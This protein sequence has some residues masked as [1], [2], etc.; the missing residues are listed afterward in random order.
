MPKPKLEY[1]LVVPLTPAKPAPAPKTPVKAA[2][3]RAAK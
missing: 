2:G 3:K 1:G